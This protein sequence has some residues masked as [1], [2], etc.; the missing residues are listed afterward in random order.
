M[1]FKSYCCTA[2]NILRKSSNLIL[3][4]LSLVIDAGIGQIN[5]GMNSIGV[6]VEDDV[7]GGRERDGEGEAM[8]CKE[9]EEEGEGE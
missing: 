1:Q 7:G 2:Y 9:K 8:E 3:N 5:Q 4:L 6:E